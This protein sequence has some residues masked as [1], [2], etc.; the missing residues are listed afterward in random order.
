MTILSR[1]KVLLTAD[2]G[3]FKENLK[4]AEKAA[5]QLKSGLG[6]MF[7]ALGLSAIGIGTVTLAL[8]NSIGAAA[9]A[10]QI[11]AQLTAV[12][13]ST[14]FA[15]QM[16]ADELN[17]LAL[18][19]SRL[20]GIEDD[21]IVKAEAVMLT[22]T[23]IGREVFPDAMTAVANMSAALGTDLQG[24]VI[25]LG[26]A[27]ND[28][29]QG[30]TALQRVGVSFTKEQKE[31]IKTLVESGRAMD[32][33]KLILAELAVEFGGAA[34]AIGDTFGGSLNKA[35]NELGN[36]SEQLGNAMMPLLRPAVSGFTEWAIAQQAVNEAMAA[37]KASRFELIL[38][39]IEIVTG[40]KTLD[41]VTQQYTDRLDDGSEARIEAATQLGRMTQ[42][43]GFLRNAQEDAKTSMDTATTDAE[44]AGNAYG[45]MSDAT[46]RLNGA[47]AAFSAQLVFN[48]AAADLDAE[49][50]LALGVAMGVVDEKTLI[51]NETLP[52]LK[53]KYDLNRDGLI[54]GKE[55]AAGYNTAVQNLYNSL[56]NLP[57]ETNVR[58]NIDVNGSVPS[59]PGS[60]PGSDRREA[61]PLANGG[62][63]WVNQPTLLMVGEG[64]EPEHVRVTPKGQVTNNYTMN[65]HTNAPGSTLRRDFEMMRSRESAN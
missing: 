57:E 58:I 2:T 24:S 21:S 38:D 12:L 8:K 50:A 10:E 62:D 61:I 16:S 3:E 28:P 55:A 18:G 56:E 27:L 33:Q 40:T 1:L 4:G 60:T 5:G 54:D 20:T 52:Q 7:G 30:V 17:D 11:N 48:K 45:Y 44:E 42:E 47:M 53:E 19:L 35:N 59:I 63:F 22:F 13:E 51:L 36:L 32:A 46:E 49:A 14:G 43:T 25:Q 6:E 9:E 31:Q 29:I 34:E 15:A 37:G 64:G 41:E 65:V 39:S 23:K 26:K